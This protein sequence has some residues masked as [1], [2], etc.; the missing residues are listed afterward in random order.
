VR[1]G[2]IALVAVALFGLVVPNGLFLFWFFCEPWTLAG[3]FSNFLALGLILDAVLATAL[4]AYFFA[5]R[6]P[7]VPPGVLRWPWFVVLVLIGGLG[8]GIPFYL[9]L[10][11]RRARSEGAGAQTF[12]EWWGTV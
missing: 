10:N 8:F 2:E 6:P 4:L 11:Y 1:R 5:S 3:L 9:W 7:G 12:A